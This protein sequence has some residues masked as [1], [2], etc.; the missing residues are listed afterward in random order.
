MFITFEGG[1]GSGKTTQSKRLAKHLQSQGKEAI[2]TREPGGTEIAEKIRAILVG[3][4]IDVRT[5]LLLAV[6][7]RVEHY[8]DVIKPAL[9]DGKIVICDRF[10]DS[11]LAYQGREVPMD[12]VIAIHKIIF[13]DMMPDKTFLV[14][15]P[16]EVGLQ[17]ASARSDAN[18][19][20]DMDP[21][22]HQQ[23]YDNF[24]EIDTMFPDRIVTIDGNRPQDEVFA[25]IL[26]E[27]S[28]L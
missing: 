1:E 16:V 28:S 10:I 14:K 18:R 22:V 23:I 6:A 8:K 27:I 15:V 12:D 19:F 17:R 9:D 25:D 24:E 20:E 21:T 2:W 11:S 4:D 13:G 5:E 7:A 3:E 26:G